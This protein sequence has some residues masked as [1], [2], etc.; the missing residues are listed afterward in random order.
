MTIDRDELER[1]ASLA[2]LDVDDDE[3]ESFADAL[4][5]IVDYVGKLEELDTDDVDPT[6]HPTSDTDPPTGDDTVEAP[7]DSDELMEG[8]PDEEAGQ[9]RVPR[10]VDS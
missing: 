8:A 1:A 10:V 5:D 9:F 2:G 6:T 4:G 3:T 7:I